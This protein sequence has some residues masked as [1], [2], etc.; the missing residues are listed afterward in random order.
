[1][2]D[3]ERTKLLKSRF[4]RA[5]T[6]STSS[7]ATRQLDSTLDEA[8]KWEADHGRGDHDGA[9]AQAAESRHEESVAESTAPVGSGRRRARVAEIEDHPDM[10]G[11][12]GR[13]L[14][15]SL[16]DDGEDKPSTM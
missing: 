4:V 10:Q 14:D 7:V 8:P 9:W 1:M 16:L 11:I 12:L 2:S 3:K 5:T 13:E 15:M 6:L